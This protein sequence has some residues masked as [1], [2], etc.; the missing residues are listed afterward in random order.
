MVG[1]VVDHSINDDVDTVVFAG[2]D[3]GGKLLL[4]S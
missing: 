3:H 1:H 2:F 4:S